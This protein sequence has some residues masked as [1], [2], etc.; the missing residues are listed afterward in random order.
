MEACEVH[1]ERGSSGLEMLGARSDE[2]IPLQSFL[3]LGLPEIDDTIQ[4]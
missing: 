2:C 4:V 1:S 3:D